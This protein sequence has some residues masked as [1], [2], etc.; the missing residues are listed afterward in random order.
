M[1]SS[2]FLESE[3]LDSK[4]FAGR[5][6]TLLGEILSHQNSLRIYLEDAFH[7]PKEYQR[8]DRD[9]D[10]EEDEESDE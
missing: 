8:E 9:T 6:L 7:V 2:K 10:Y 3:T 1:M 5:V 4:I